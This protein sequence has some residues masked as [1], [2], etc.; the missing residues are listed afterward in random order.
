[1]ATAIQAQ[2]PLHEL[3]RRDELQNENL[4]TT[5][6]RIGQVYT[7]TAAGFGI[8]CLSAYLFSAA[9][10][11]GKVVTLLTGSAGLL[12]GI[13]LAAV[14]IGLIVAM[15][16]SSNS[17]LKHGFYSLFTVYQGVVLSPLVLANGTAFAIGSLA[18]TGIIG[19][20]GAV[21]LKIHTQFQRFEKILFVALCAIGA[22]SLGAL[23]LPGIAG[24]ALNQISI[25]GGLALF[26]AY[27]IYD[28]QKMR[29]DANFN[30]PHF[31][32]I[33]HATKLYLNAM[34]IL[35]R[36]YEIMDKRS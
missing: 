10:L 33:Q 1:M 22:A 2:A 20:L 35:I 19:G 12:T 3:E 11:A 15:H 9:G 25:Y 28:T 4:A 6:E 8:S 26:G 16:F 21:A 31:E 18:T 14:G 5:N 27:V 36:L 29:E 30:G 13:G 17:G 34:N 23:V 32:P 7:Y 24:A